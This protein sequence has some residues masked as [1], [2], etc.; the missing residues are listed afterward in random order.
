MSDRAY[1]SASNVMM[2]RT[3][4]YTTDTN[5]QPNYS[6]SRTAQLTSSTTNTLGND[7]TSS[8]T[9]A[10]EMRVVDGA[11]YVNATREIGIA[12]EE[13]PAMPKGWVMVQSGD[14]WPALIDLD[15]SHILRNIDS[16]MVVGT[17][18]LL[19]LEQLSDITLTSGTLEDGTPVDQ[20]TVT[21]TADILATAISA[22]IAARGDEPMLIMFDPT[23]TMVTTYSLNTEDQLLQL[24]TNLTMIWTGAD[25]HALDSSAAE[26]TM[27]NQE[28]SDT[29]RVVISGINEPVEPV[30][31]PEM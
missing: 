7:T 8:Y 30:A 3:T 6:L 29:E 10:S 22:T 21:W 18:E 24:D 19:L 17:E 4:H 25:Y 16:P 13:L 9:V 20:I 11:L 26:G 5:G 14:E 27:L 12:P 28:I 31:A 23:S 2:T 1:Q 15:M